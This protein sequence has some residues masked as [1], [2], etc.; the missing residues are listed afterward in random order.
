MIDVEI[1]LSRSS[2]SRPDYVNVRQYL[3][4]MKAIATKAPIDPLMISATGPR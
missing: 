1:L 4:A 2:G 3:A